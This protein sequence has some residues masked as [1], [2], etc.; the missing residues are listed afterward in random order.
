MDEKLLK[1]IQMN[2]IG[3]VEFIREVKFSFGYDFEEILHTNIDDFI[4]IVL[5]K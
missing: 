5:K 2:E 1:I 4:Q 3:I